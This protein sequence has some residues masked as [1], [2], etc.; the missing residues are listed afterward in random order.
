MG[1]F[2]AFKSNVT[3]TPKIA[4]CGSMIYMLAADGEV[5]QEEILYLNTI[6]ND[7]ATLKDSVKYIKNKDVDSFVAEAADI[8]DDKQKMVVLANILD[9][10]FSDGNADESEQELFRKFMDAF[11]KTEEDVSEIFD[12]IILK[13]DKSIFE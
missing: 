4:L 1:L 3:L 10:L 12:V 5:E 13:N 11:G 9:L 8:L 2:D 7:E 6:V